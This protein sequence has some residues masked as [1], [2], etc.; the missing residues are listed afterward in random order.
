MFCRICG[1]ELPQDARFCSGC[2]A[3]VDVSIS[4]SQSIGGDRPRDPLKWAIAG[5]VVMIVIVA[6]C[7]MVSYSE[8]VPERTHG[9]VTIRGDMVRDD[10][11]IVGD[12]L[13]YDG[14]D[15]VWYIK[16]LHAPYLVEAGSMYT[17]RGY[18]VV[19]GR[20][21]SPGPGEYE[22][23]LNVNGADVA[24]GQ[25]IVRGT[26]VDSYSWT[27]VIDGKAMSFTV[28]YDYTLDEFL[29]YS[30]DDAVRWQVVSLSDARFVT[31]DASVQRLVNALAD[32]YRAV[33]GQ[34][35]SLADQRYADYLL[36]FVQCNIT[37]PPTV[38]S[39]GGSYVWDDAG[40]GDIYLYGVEEYWAYPME[41][42]YTKQGDCEDTTILLCSIY[43][44][45][46]FGSAMVTV[47][48][49]MLAA[50]ELE[51]F[52]PRMVNPSVVFTAKRIPDHEFNLY[53]CETTFENAVPVGYVS[54]G[55]SREVSLLDEV[56]FVPPYDH[57]R[58]VPA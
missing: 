41:T 31:V 49:H 22:V 3:S 2:G 39:A 29:K 12:G 26:I 58:E 18:D 43:S 13:R 24:K 23:V 15:C 6:A 16:D 20:D 52:Q 14:T 8:D 56:T 25:L 37:Y 35:V 36:S 38:S 34:D 51:G 54:S 19:E 28:D 42:L 55:T 4:A 47:P 40:N 7:I 32:G 9:N 17:V 27:A 33:Y 10:I 50:V 57:R 11:S 44:V 5:L 46:G 21:L 48:G 53:F 1:K 45:A 30:H